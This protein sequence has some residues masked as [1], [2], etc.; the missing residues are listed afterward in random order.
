MPGKLSKTRHLE[1][2]MEGWI[3]KYLYV[4]VGSENF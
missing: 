2:R 1:K 4:G 3:C